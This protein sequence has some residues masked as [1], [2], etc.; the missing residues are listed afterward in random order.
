MIP[1]TVSNLNNNS[2]GNPCKNGH[3]E[4]QRRRN[5]S[6]YVCS[7]TFWYFFTDT[8]IT[9]KSDS[10]GVL[11][12]TEDS[13]ARQ[14]VSISLHLLYLDHVTN[15]I[16]FDWTH[17]LLELVFQEQVKCQVVRVHVR[18]MKGMEGEVEGIIPSSAPS[19]H[20][21]PPLAWRSIS[22]DCH[23]VSLQSFTQN[24]VH[25]NLLF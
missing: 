25:E 10:L 21:K 17:S 16:W 7:L 9:T 22:L 23:W 5:K 15:T 20:E 24:S 4:I 11:Y 14:G 8:Y 18:I 1:H 6:V 3:K 19:P 2:R 13:M 12:G